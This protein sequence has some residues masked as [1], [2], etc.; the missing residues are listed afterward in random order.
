[1]EKGVLAKGMPAWVPVIGAKKSA[2]AVAYIL[3]F[4]Q[5]GEPIAV[6]AAWIPSPA[7]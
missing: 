2:E 1:L 5:E 6:Q 3:S 4:H 7:K